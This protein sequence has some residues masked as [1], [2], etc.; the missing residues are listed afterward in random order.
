MH[1]EHGWG[2]YD[3]CDMNKPQDWLK[4]ARSSCYSCITGANVCVSPPTMLF[5]QYLEYL[6]PERWEGN[7]LSVKSFLMTQVCA[8]GWAC[9]GAHLAV[10]GSP[11]VQVVSAWSLLTYD[12]VWCNPNMLFQC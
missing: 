5:H 9:A 10:Q 7:M 6:H 11:E 3:Q 8:A 4:R 1:N 2:P 12:A